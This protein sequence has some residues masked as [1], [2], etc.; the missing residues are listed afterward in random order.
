MSVLQTLRESGLTARPSK[1]F[2]GFGSLEFLGHVVGEGVI[3]PLPDKITKITKVA[4]PKTKKEVRSFIGLT[5]YYRR[6]IPNFAA[7]AAPLTD[8][9]KSGGPREIEWGDA[10]QKAFETLKAR[11]ATSPILHLPDAEKVFI[12]RTDASDTGLGAVLMQPEGDQNFPVCYAS[13]KLLPREQ[14]YSVIERECLALVWA[15][16]KFHIYLYGK[17][18]IAETDHHP[19]ALLATAKLNNSRVI[20]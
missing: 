7:I 17:E 2:L 5:S 11:L 6:F 9:T 14:K 12:L 1:C 8:L 4:R 20:R 18:F 15:I 13:R 19:L 10:Q 3:K 16:A